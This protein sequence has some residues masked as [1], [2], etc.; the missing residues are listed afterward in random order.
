MISILNA[1][2]LAAELDMLNLLK[3]ASV[4]LNELLGCNTVFAVSLRSSTNASM[5]IVNLSI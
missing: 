4:T 2:Y 5:E 3:Y 1:A